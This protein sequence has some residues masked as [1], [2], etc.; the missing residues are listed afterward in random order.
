[1]RRAHFLTISLLLLAGLPARAAEVA[2]SGRFG[3]AGFSGGAADPDGARNAP[4]GGL[5]AS[6]AS[7]RWLLSKAELVG[8]ATEDRLYDHAPTVE[9]EPGLAALVAITVSDLLERARDIRF[10]PGT[11]KLTEPSLSF[12][13]ELAGAL[14][15]EASA[16]LEIVVHTAGSGDAK[17]D[18]AFSKRRADVIR[19]TLVERGAAGEQLLATGRG[20]EDPVAPNLT[21]TGRMR[22][23]RVELHRWRVP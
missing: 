13:S 14:A 11:L 19:Q 5:R 20:S 9:S 17:K 18:L 4:L 22:N 15:K 12:L 8:L 1:M 16:R 6:V 10:E 3:A 2:A 23:E 7:S 21:R